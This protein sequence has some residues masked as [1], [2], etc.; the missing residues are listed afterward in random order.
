LWVVKGIP[1][2]GD[3]VPMAAPLQE[4]LD[5]IRQMM[6]V[7]GEPEQQYVPLARDVVEDAVGLDDLAL[8]D[9]QVTYAPRLFAQMALPYRDPGDIPRW[10]RTNGAM[11]MTMR[12]GEWH[13][14]KTG[15]MREGYPYGII[16]RL[17]VLWITTEVVHTRHREVILGSSLRAFVASM[18]LWPSGGPR[19]DSHRVV[20][21]LRRLVTASIVVND[22]RDLG[23][24]EHLYRTGMFTFADSFQLWQPGDGF[25]WDGTLKL[26]EQ[27][28][29]SIV[30]G[31]IPLDP[32][33]LIELRRRSRSPMALDI[34]AWLAHRLHRLKKPKPVLISWPDLAAQ[35]GGDYGR[36]RA[37]KAQFV[38]DLAHVLV[39]YPTA[40]VEPEKDGL[41][42]RCSPTPIPARAASGRRRPAPR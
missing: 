13:D 32:G 1:P 8:D 18:G 6:L 21:Q 22:A 26:S 16:P 35:F 4:T 33:S 7:R 41:R 19:G 15:E 11:T 3:A 24:N 12:P 10:R 14:D 31:S 2:T 40:R 25:R 9:P 5:G 29:A 42:L 28:H 36:I 39:V 27:F 34:Y 37:F 38:K 23:G 17:L 30:G 20:D